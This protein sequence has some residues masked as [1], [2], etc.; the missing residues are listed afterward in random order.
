MSPALARWILTTEPPGEPTI[1][2]LKGKF[3]WYV[4]VF[5]KNS[6]KRCHVFNSKHVGGT[7]VLLQLEPQS[8]LGKTQYHHT[9]K[10]PDVLSADMIGQLA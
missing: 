2:A 5:Q 7:S 4:V 10:V 9:L 8:D 3:C 6:S 1:Q